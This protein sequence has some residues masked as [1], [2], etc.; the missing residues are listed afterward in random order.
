MVILLDDLNN[1]KH[2]KKSKDPLQRLTTLNI[3]HLSFPHHY[4]QLTIFPFSSNQEE[5]INYNVIFEIRIL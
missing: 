2:P 4:K 3:F 5:N 1:K